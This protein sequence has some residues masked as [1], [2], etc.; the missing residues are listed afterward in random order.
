MSRLF[1]NLYLDEDVSV[2]IATLMRS[3]GLSAT[4]TIEAG[5]GGHSDAVQL[6]FAAQRQLAILTHNRADFERLAAE[7]F[8]QNRPHAGII[9]AVRR[10]PY[11]IARR[12]L[13]LINNVTA[14]E[15]DNQVMYV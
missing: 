12:L 5:N 10:T 15:M 8:E 2:L 4:T 1:I 9:I 6:A 14:D 3:R 7:Y 13:T 11:E